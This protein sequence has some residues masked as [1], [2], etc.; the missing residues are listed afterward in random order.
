MNN[1]SY[2]K[3]DEFSM[4]QKKIKDTIESIVPNNHIYNTSN[5][6]LCDTSDDD[7]HNKYF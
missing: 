3:D 6:S 1:N 4:M 5:N 2:P 7:S